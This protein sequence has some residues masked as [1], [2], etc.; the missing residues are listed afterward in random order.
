MR[1]ILHVITTINRGGAENQLLILARA[2]TNSGCEVEVVFL[3][4][5][6]E[7]Q[8]DFESSGIKVNSFLLGKHPLIQLHLFRKYI[9]DYSGVIHA[10]LPRAE[11]LAA[12]SIRDFIF[13]RHNAEAFFPGAPRIFSIVL[14]RFVSTRAKLGIAISEAVRTFLYQSKEIG[15]NFE[16]PVVYYGIESA[17]KKNQLSPAIAGNHPKIGT[18]S[19]LVPQ[20]DLRTLIS[21]FSLVLT[22]FPMAELLIA[23]AGQLEIELKDFARNLGVDSRIKWLGRIA[24]TESFYLSINTFVL[25]STYE[26]FGLVLLEAMNYGVPVVATNVSAIPEVIGFDHPLISDLSNPNSFANNIIKSL[27][28]GNRK[29]ILTYQSERIAEFST[30]TLVQKLERFYA[31]S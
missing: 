13:S 5:E 28:D 4:G 22:D 2:Q 1:R 31:K 24:D 14:S 11:L 30:D 8:F 3:K 10:H 26:G 16:I 17:A 27:D 29:S 21:A 20:K 6:P 23:G 15:K 19:R 18:I 25:S 7:L 9:R 12:L